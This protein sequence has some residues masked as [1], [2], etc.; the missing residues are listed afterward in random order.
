MQSLSNFKIDF[1]QF[2]NALKLNY[3]TQYKYK[4]IDNRQE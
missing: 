4:V 1:Q 3:T 2:L